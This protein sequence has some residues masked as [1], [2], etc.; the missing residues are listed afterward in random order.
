MVC[1][2]ELIRLR[3]ACQG[4]RLDAQSLKTLRPLIERHLRILLLATWGYSLDTLAQ[5]C[6][7]T[8]ETMQ[9]LLRRIRKRAR[10]ICSVWMSVP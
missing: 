8:P 6:G 10:P 4:N 3:A 9:G 1:Q 7:E 5:A 2:A